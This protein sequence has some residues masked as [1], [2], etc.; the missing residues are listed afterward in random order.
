MKFYIVVN[1]ETGEI[2]RGLGLSDPMYVSNIPYD[3]A[4]ETLQEAPAGVE[5]GLLMENYYKDSSGNFVERP[6]RPAE[7]YNWT[8]GGWELD[9]AA[10]LEDLRKTRDYLLSNTDWTQVADAPVNAAEWA[11]YRQ[12]LRDLPAQYQTE[13]DFANVVWPTPPN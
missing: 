6:A 1:N 9:L 5:V 2:T 7:F 12:E 3:A 11:A 10:A 4:A 8:A 13:T